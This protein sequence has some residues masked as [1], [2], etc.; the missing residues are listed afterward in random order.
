MFNLSRKI[1]HW[2]NLAAPRNDKKAGEPALENSRN[3]R[4]L[5]GQNYSQIPTS[6]RSGSSCIHLL[7]V[8]P[9][10]TGFPTLLI[11]ITHSRLKVWWEC[12]TDH[13]WSCASSQ[14]VRHQRPQVYIT[15]S[16]STEDGTISAT[17]I[18]KHMKC[19]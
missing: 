2:K 3:Q 1:I 9:L 6:R 10:K 7:A 16:A 18:T 5:D 13:A 15:F 11:C 17:K 4:K 14:A 8:M 19:I 12:P